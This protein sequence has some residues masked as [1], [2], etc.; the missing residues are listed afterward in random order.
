MAGNLEKRVERL[1]LRN[2]TVAP[3]PVIFLADVDDEGED[4]A[5]ARW[6]AEHG[7]SLPDNAFLVRF[8]GLKP[9]PAP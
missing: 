2:E 3:R 7:R 5:I 4:A 6:E 1:E 8:V 9:E